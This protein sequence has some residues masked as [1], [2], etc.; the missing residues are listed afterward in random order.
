MVLK[1]EK[2]F[3][4]SSF[5]LAVALLAG[6]PAPARAQE[7]SQN[8]YYTPDLTDQSGILPD[9]ADR[10]E[11]TGEHVGSFWLLPTLKAG[12]F[13]DSNVYGRDHDMADGYG[14]VIQPHVDLKSDWGRHALNVSLD[15]T[16]FDY[17]GKSSLNRDVFQ[18]AADGRI[19]IKRDL[20]LAGG[21]KGGL[22]DD[23]VGDLNSPGSAAEPVRHTDMRAWGSLNKVFNRLSV[24]IGGAYEIFDYNN[25]R[26]D[27]GTIIDQQFR[28][29]RQLE[30]GSRVAYLV[31]PGFRI[32]GDFRY[33]WRDY[34]RGSA[35][36]DGWRGLGG[37]EMDM[38]HALRGEASVGYM[39]QYYSPGSTVGGLAYHAGLIWNPTPLMTINLDADRLVADSAIAGTSSAIEDR[40]RLSLDYEALRG[41]VI[42][43][44]IAY[45]R[46]DYTGL[47]AAGHVLDA[48][49]RAE[50]AMNRYMS[51]GLSY[52]FSATRA[53]DSGRSFDDFNR[54]L[55]LAYAKAR[56]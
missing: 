46:L 21:V 2:S 19:D 49:L 13:Y 48:G 40:L 3:S 9:V 51:I 14:G 41:L 42:T 31:S 8:E 36:S 7:A 11:G 30:A 27:I 32:F 50:Y 12:A 56:L 44:S 29:S 38:T 47:G 55:V 33:N 6:L 18:A 20:V 24:S 23:A 34:T 10:Y 45:E 25:V 54:H 15:A 53:L 1:R 35:N 17:F 39:A 37:V 26:S 5:G 22:F 28:D 16:H 43:P 52:D 4:A